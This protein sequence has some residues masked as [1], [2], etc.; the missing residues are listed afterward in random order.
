VASAR[1]AR[2]NYTIKPERQRLQAHALER[3]TCGMQQSGV[4]F[5][6]EIAT[7]SNAIAKKKFPG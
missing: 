4:L 6:N 1:W 2:Q 5:P 7:F 3:P